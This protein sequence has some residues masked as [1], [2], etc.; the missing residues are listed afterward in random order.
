MEILCFYA[1]I[2]F[3]LVDKVYPL[4][5]LSLI[6]YFRLRLVYVGWFVFAICI[7]YLHAYLNTTHGMPNS[8][9]YPRAKLFG[10]ISSIPI[11]H[12]NYIQFEF[13]AEQLENHRVRAKILLYCYKDCPDLRVGQQ[14]VLIAKL[15]KPRNLGNPGSFNYVKW[16]LTRHIEWTGNVFPQS[17]EFKGD[18]YVSIFSKIRAALL[19]YSLH[20]GLDE[21]VLGVMEALSLGATSHISKQQWELFSH[22]GTT[23][24]I[25]IS[26][27]HISMIAGM[28][29]FLIRWIWTRFSLL[30]L[31]CPAQK[32]GSLVAILIS[33]F[34]TG[35]T[36]FSI[37]AQRALVG[38]ILMLSRNLLPFQISIWQAWR[39]SLFTVLIIEPHSVMMIGFY[40]SFIGIAILML[41][42]QRY[43]ATGFK[44]MFI[45]QLACL[46]GLMP[47]TLFWFSYGAV[48]GIIANLFAIPLVELWIVPLSLFVILLTKWIIVPGSLWLLKYSILI[49]L[50][51]LKWVNFVSWF[52]FTIALTQ[53]IVPISL[54]VTLLT[55]VCLP[56]KRLI[57]PLSILICAVLYPA[58]KDI[59]DG[60]VRMDVLDVGQG[61]SVVVR[62]S[63]HTIIYDTGM[64]FFQ[65]SD[66]AKLA[67]LP[68]LNTIGIKKIDA[69]IISHTDLDHRGGLE[70]L[71]NQLSI[72]KLIV[73]SPD[74]YHKGFSCHEYP[75][76]TWDQVSFRFFY[77]PKDLNK[78]NHSCVL[79]IST[80]NQN[81]LLTGDIEKRAEQ[82]LV[83]NY[84]KELKSSVLLIPHHGSKT[85]SS[86]EFVRMVAPKYAIA[87]YGFDNRYHFP[88]QQALQIY[89]SQSIKVLN[90]AS[91]GMITFLLGR[92]GAQMYTQIGS[93]II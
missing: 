4:L 39:Y 15:K 62:T 61:L 81:V 73:D 91:N 20:L 68:Y 1:G 58:R 9:I 17:F 71:E 88:H 42:N 57:L 38:C 51:L 78:N 48:N 82:Y 53:V 23:H 8:A 40:L 47:L 3:L 59:K 84:G 35:I 75:S 44:K 28:V 93:M 87:S 31:L 65:G 25:D 13:Q 19:T 72:K 10:K 41:M 24:L 86:I 37:P 11:V 33:F 56:L 36:G 18:A 92:S 34:Y 76:W 89:N 43:Q 12:E 55:L 2:V 60:E 50:G 69:V 74:F 63:K 70:S 5:L 49:F 30:C 32:A 52:N 90:T 29:F 79:K 26:G 83:N 64:K 6:L 22:T 80:D 66:M 46:I 45:L 7:G 21:N 14:W 16:L 77:L 27:A 85:S 67:I 54:M